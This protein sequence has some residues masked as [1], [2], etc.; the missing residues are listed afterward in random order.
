MSREEIEAAGCEFDEAS[1]QR[2]QQRL[3]NYQINGNRPT[4]APSE[5]TEST[6]DARLSSIRWELDMLRNHAW[7]MVT[8]WYEAF[9]VARR[10]WAFRECR[11]ETVMEPWTIPNECL[12]QGAEIL[13]GVE[14][15]HSTN[16][17]LDLY[18]W[19][20][21]A[22]IY[23]E[24]MADV[25]RLAAEA[26]ERAAAQIEAEFGEHVRGVPQ[27]MR[28]NNPQVWAAELDWN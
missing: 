7:G 4:L 18:F 23:A 13:D 8:D 27:A 2:T 11:D 6:I 21:C 19:D 28:K 24:Q 3:A 5:E 10:C 20:R 15:G 17:A 16:I 12:I 14:P 22:A 25:E 9:A 1:R 26:R